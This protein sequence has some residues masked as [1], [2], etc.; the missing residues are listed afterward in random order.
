MAVKKV[1]AK[2]IA[3][4]RDAQGNRYRPQFDTRHE[5]N[6][7]YTHNKEKI[8]KGEFL[9]PAKVP[10]FAEVA[11]EWLASRADRRPGVY[12]NYSNHIQG[13]WIP[14]LGDLRL[15]RV[16]VSTIEKLRD[17]MRGKF[18]ISTVRN[19]MNT[20]SQV[21]KYSLRKKYLVV[22]P[23]LA[24]ERLHERSNEIVDGVDTSD[25]RDGT[26]KVKPEDVLNVLEIRQ[27]L[28]AARPGLYRTLFTIA[29]STGARSGELFALTWDDVDFDAGKISITKSLSWAKG[30]ETTTRVRT[31]P[32]KTESSRREIPI[33]HEVAVMLKSWKLQCPPGALVFPATDGRPMRRSTVYLRGFVPALKAAGLRKVRLHSLRH[34]FAS[35]LIA[36]GTPISQVSSLLGHKDSVVTLRVYTH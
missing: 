29:A 31:Y 34:S 16:D 15:G 18:A 27:L 20:L 8:R 28:D 4:F 10:S 32:P 24:V 9:A 19:R 2:W 12:D 33:P 17:D 30:T 25:Q 6:A 21:L 5:A 14:Q 22:N 13:F 3:D 11:L 36:Q 7:A 35:T 1:G 26:Q 23:M